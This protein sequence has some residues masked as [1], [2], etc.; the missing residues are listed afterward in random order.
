MQISNKNLENL[1]SQYAEGNFK[2]V[3][4]LLLKFKESFN[5]AH[6]S[7]NLGTIHA[8]QGNL[9]I[10]KYHFEKS[11]NLGFIGEELDNNLNFV[12]SS[13]KK[14]IKLRFLNSTNRKQK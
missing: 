1:K 10:A 5:D 7:Y 4:K 8:K 13:L 2:E 9:A 12:N 3:E 14:L 6:F 11:A